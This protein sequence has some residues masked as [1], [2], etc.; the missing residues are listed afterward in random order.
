VEKQ[1][2]KNDRLGEITIKPKCG[3]PEVMSSG[4]WNWQ[5]LP[6]NSYILQVELFVAP[7]ERRIERSYMEARGP[8]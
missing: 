1:S 4:L 2:R 8:F 7:R 5:A 3:N 6:R